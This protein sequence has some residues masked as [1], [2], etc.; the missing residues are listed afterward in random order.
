MHKNCFVVIFVLISLSAQAQLDALF[1]P[2]DCREHAEFFHSEPVAEPVI[3]ADTIVVAE[4]LTITIDSVDGWK[5]W[6]FVENYSFGKD[7]G[8]MPMIT[9]LNSLHPFFRDKVKQ[10]IL[11]CKA[12]GIELAV[13]EAYRTHAK[14]HEY[15]VKGKKYTSSG[16][17]RSKHQYGLAVDLV[18]IVD[19]VA[20]WD[21]TA[22]WK[23]IGTTGEK[24]GLRWGGRWRKPYDPG[25]F[26]W[27]GGLTSTHL[28]AGMLPVVPN[29]EQA[30]P[31]LKEDIKQLRKYWSSWETSQSALTRK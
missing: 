30:Y 26:E 8:D 10:L 13:V 7:R 20:V 31:C 23:K 16:A 18:P 4:E 27:T 2:F 9:D 22:L 28:T 5:S 24:L 12:N 17:G 6:S 25:H 1:A 21:N 3:A 11:N 15:K 19:S 14:Q 29:V